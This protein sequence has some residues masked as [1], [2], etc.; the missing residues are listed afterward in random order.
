M[1]FDLQIPNWFAILI[2]LIPAFALFIYFSR[3]KGSMWLAFILGGA[4]WFGALLLRLLPLQLP[5]VIYGQ[6]F[7]SNLVYFGYAS[8]LAGLFEEGIRYICIKKA[9]FTREDHRH[10]LSFG[11]GWGFLEAVLIYALSVLAILIFMPE[12]TFME[13]LL[14]P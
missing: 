13:L 7:A 2:A 4:G 6:D 8:L 14:E 12:L 1:A 9:S 10:V 11:L 5:L 3:A